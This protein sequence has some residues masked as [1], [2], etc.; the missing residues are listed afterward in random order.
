MAAP[1]RI[2]ST[3][4]C[5]LL[6]TTVLGLKIFNISSKALQTKA[7][8]NYYALRYIIISKF[9]IRF[10]TFWDSSHAHAHTVP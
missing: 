10:I 5:R 1:R 7:L 6:A 8:L 2:I 4:P 9:V 3:I